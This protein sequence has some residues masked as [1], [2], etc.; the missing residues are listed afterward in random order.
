MIRFKYSPPSLKTK[1]HANG[2][3]QLTR[4]RRSRLGHSITAWPRA[5][6]RSSHNHVLCLH[7]FQVD[8]R[9]CYPQSCIVNFEQQRCNMIASRSKPI[10]RQKTIKDNLISLIQLNRD[11]QSNRPVSVRS[12]IFVNR[13]EEN[14]KRDHINQSFTIQLNSSGQ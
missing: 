13:Y 9:W 6:M 12:T 7:W 5:E 14:G 8:K 1:S 3:K 4:C 10:N 2:W 11:G